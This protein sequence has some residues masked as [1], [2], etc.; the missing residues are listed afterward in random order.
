MRGVRGRLFLAFIGLVALTA[1][2]SSDEPQLMNI[3]TDT[4]DE[5]AI[6]PTK[7]LEVPE[8]YASLPTP[9]PGEGNL[10]DPNPRGDAVAALGGDPNRLVR[11]GINPGEQTLIAYATRYGVPG[12]IRQVLARE[13]LEWRKTNNGRLLERMFNVNV[14]YSSYKPMSLDQHLELE[15]MR[16]KGIWTPS[17]PPDPQVRIE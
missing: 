13:D 8:T 7:P 11:G 3:R 6:L 17:A 14:Y 1:C 5:F 12:D 16:A 10:V 2:D 4:P 9:T 15:R